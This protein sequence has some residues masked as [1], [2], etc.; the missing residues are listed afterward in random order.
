MRVRINIVL[1]TIKFCFSSR[2]IDLC[3][4]EERGKKSLAN[5]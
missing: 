2:R 5:W 1:L 4:D 3:V